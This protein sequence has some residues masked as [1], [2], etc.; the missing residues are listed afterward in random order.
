[1]SLLAVTSSTWMVTGLGFGLVLVLLF[2]FVY[3]MKGLG[4]VMQTRGKAEQKP[5]T[6][7]A[8]SVANTQEVKEQGMTAATEAAIAMALHLYYNG[9]HDEEPTKITLVHDDRRYSP[10]NSKIFGMNNL[11]RN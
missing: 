6:A 4:L 5:T 9:V 7:P 11:H 10:W 1:M 8:K 2:V 3:I